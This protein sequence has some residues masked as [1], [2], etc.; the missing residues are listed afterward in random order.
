M[1]TQRAGRGGPVGG[2]RAR[3]RGTHPYPT[4]VAPCVAAAGGPRVGCVLLS[5]SSRVWRLPYGSRRSRTL[6]ADSPRSAIAGGRT[7]RPP[8]PC[9]EPGHLVV[10]R[11]AAASSQC[12]LV[13]P[14]GPGLSASAPR[15]PTFPPSVPRRWL[16]WNN[17]REPS[18]V[19]RCSLS[20]AHSVACPPVARNP[21]PGLVQGSKWAGS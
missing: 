16:L 15:Q 10:S 18:A 1:R 2:A 11:R 13:S 21:T 6:R 3:R 5:S 14:I 9:C 20:C 17:G 8:P 12:R 19:R 4:P 7:R